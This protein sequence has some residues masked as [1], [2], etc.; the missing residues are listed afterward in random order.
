MKPVHYCI[1]VSQ[2]F[3]GSD[4]PV[5]FQGGLPDAMQ[6]AAN[7]GFDSVEIH[8]RNPEDW[9]AEVL[10]EL[11]RR[12]GVGI[13]AIGTGLEYSLHGLSFTHPD[14]GVR[15][16]TVVKFR[17]FIDLA[18]RL[19]SVVFVGLCRGTSPDAGSVEEYLDRFAAELS[20]VVAY[21][22][23]RGVVLG[24]EPIA[25]YMTNLLTTTAQTLAFTERPGLGS[26]ELLLDT[27]H[28]DREDG[29]IARAFA[30]AAGRVAHVHISDS[31]RKAPGSGEI[32]FA[33]VGRVLRDIGY[34]RA[35]SLEILPVPS[36]ELA[37]KQGLRW[38]R[39]VW[40]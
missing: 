17:S 19:D 33:G 26:I 30:A 1:A 16:A 3:L 9:D 4:A 18:A 10:G 5:V 7:M 32:D 29:G 35:V 6:R 2:E 28:M 20:P 39:S 21:A 22:D 31:D 25:G 40:R 13:D 27:H 11:S 12:S 38:M 36:D 24:L 14:P 15:A 23:E 8:I 37:A 34:D